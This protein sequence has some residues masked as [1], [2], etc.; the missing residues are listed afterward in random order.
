MSFNKVILCSGHL[1]DKA[2][3]Q[4]PRFPEKKVSL[5]QE[6]IA[7]QLDKLEVGNNDLAICGGARGSDILFAELCADKGAHVWLIISLNEEEFL[8]QSVRQPGT[9]WEQRFYELRKKPEVQTFWMSDLEPNQSKDI[10]PF[11]A[12]NIKM[13]QMG[14]A[15]TSSPGNL[16]A[17]L[18]WDQQPVGDGPGGTADFAA[19]VK[20]AGGQVA[21]INPLEL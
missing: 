14:I 15:E 9:N 2:D 10:S 18:I 8:Q 11:A 5:V 16:Y 4:K 3:R 7:H 19:R 6:Q 20:E 12:A 21:I 1:T 13:I 17:I